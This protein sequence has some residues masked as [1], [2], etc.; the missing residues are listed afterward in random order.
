[1]NK[2]QYSTTTLNLYHDNKKALGDICNNYNISMTA[3]FNTFIEAVACGAIIPQPTEFSKRK[4]IVNNAD[5]P[6]EAQL[7]I[8]FISEKGEELY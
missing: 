7:R 4:R 5:I 2:H 8:H 6:I 3:L 1:M